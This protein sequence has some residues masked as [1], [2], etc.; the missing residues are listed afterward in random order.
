M[1]TKHIIYIYKQE[2]KTNPKIAKNKMGP[3]LALMLPL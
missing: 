1:E 3:K 2:N